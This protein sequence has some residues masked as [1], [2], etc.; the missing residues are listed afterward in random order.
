MEHLVNLGNDEFVD[1]VFGRLFAHFF[2]FFLH[3][4]LLLLLV[5]CRS[6]RNLGVADGMFCIV[7]ARPASTLRVFVAK[8]CWQTGQS[9][10]K[11]WH[12]VAALCCWKALE[13]LFVVRENL[14]EGDV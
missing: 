12:R 7:R 14:K 13:R 8:C 6:H 10:G 9:G 2:F 4:V 11:I 1:T 5:D 3:V